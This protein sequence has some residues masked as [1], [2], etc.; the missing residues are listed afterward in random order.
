[1]I[2]IIITGVIVSGAAFAAVFLIVKRFKK[3]KKKDPCEGCSSECGDCV[4][5]KEITKSKEPK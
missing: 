4:L 5:H 2:Q 3:S 1:M